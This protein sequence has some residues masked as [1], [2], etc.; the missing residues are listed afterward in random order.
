[1]Y[2]IIIQEKAE[3]DLRRIVEYITD[4][5][6]ERNIALKIYKEIS[7][8]IMSLEMMPKRCP[9]IDLEPFK[10]NDIRRLIINNYSAFY[11]VNEETSTVHI[12]HIVYN[13]REWQNII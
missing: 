13:H 6:C 7:Q 5:L 2:E 10:R 3:N 9:V 8:G 11:F 12:L 4:C 1:M